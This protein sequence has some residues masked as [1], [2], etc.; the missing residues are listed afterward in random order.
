[1]DAAI[2]L[3]SNTVRLLLARF[4]NHQLIPLEYHRAVTRLAGHFSLERGLAPESIE[5]TLMVLEHYS[6]MLKRIRL[7]TLHVVGTE[8]IRKAVNQQHFLS[9]VS[10]RTALQLEI[11]S[12]EAEARL[13]AYGALE[14]LEPRP[15]HSLIVDIGG[16]STEL[17]LV[18]NRQVLWHASQPLGVV[19]LLE[20]HST[21]AERT[22]FLLGQLE[23]IEASLTVSGFS[24]LA[25]APSTCLV[26]TAGTVTTLAAMLL[27]MDPYQGELVNNYCITTEHL[28]QL[29]TELT[30]LTLEK[31]RQIRGL[32]AGREDLIIPGLEILS[33]LLKFLQKSQ[34][35]V[36]DYGL[37]EGLIICRGNP[38]CT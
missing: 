20:Q 22:D 17:T 7:R 14:I 30:G 28:A 3:G 12:G 27:K 21:D 35:I 16:G 18:S 31:R 8:V 4:D 10:N 15:A 34:M 11:L 23:E 29:R 37:L 33:R 36:S 6:G 13:S 9:E 5:R 24:E 38:F 19:T 2:D 26:G 32:E 1:V 25:K